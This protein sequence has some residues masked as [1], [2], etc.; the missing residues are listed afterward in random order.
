MMLAPEPVNR[1][2]S[3]LP[4]GSIRIVDGARARPARSTPPR[5]LDRVR[6]A[7]RARH[8]SRRTEK[9]YVH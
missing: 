9:A 1:Y 8:Y 3:P 4:G 2:R 6:E 5:F 7:I